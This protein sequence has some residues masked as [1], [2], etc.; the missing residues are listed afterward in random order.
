MAVRLSRLNTK[1]SSGFALDLITVFEGAPW[2]ALKAW[3]RRPFASVERLYLAMVEA[4]DAGERDKQVALLKAQPDVVAKARRYDERADVWE[5]ER[6]KEMFGDMTDE[7]FAG[8]KQLLDDYAERFGY[9]FIVDL[10]GKSKDD[11]IAAV[12]ER[13]ENNPDA[14]LTTSLSQMSQIARHRLERQIK[15]N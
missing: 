12:S 5:R 15:I 9:P 11:L 10:R 14:E 7:E 8:F 1:A 6:A 2:I 3:Q 13:V 4:L